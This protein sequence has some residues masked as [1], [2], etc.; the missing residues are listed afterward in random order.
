MLRYHS[1]QISDSSSPGCHGPLGEPTDL[2]WCR[3]AATKAGLKEFTKCGWDL[4]VSKDHCFLSKKIYK[5]P[6]WKNARGQK[7]INKKKYHT[8]KNLLNF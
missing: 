3:N 2:P 7:S 8:E 5:C 1:G 4:G 6:L